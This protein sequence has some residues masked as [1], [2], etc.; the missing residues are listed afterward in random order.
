MIPD[1]YTENA[2]Q[3]IQALEKEGNINLVIIEIVE[4]YTKLRAFRPELMERVSFYL[5]NFSQLLSPEMIHA[6][7]SLPLEDLQNFGLSDK[8][9]AFHVTSP[10]PACG[11]IYFP[12]ISTRGQ[13]YEIRIIKENMKTLLPL[14]LELLDQ[15]GAPAYSV[16]Q[17][18]LSCNLFWDP[19][20][21][22]FQIL[23]TFGREDATVSGESMGLP[24]ALALY[25]IETKKDL[26]PN[27]S[28]TA[29][30]KRDGSVEPVAG[31]KEK[32]TAL[33]RERH[34]VNTVFVS[35]RQEINFTIR[36]LKIVKVDSLKD[37]INMA[38]TGPVDPSAFPAGID[39]GA[40][41]SRIKRQYKNHLIDTCLG[42]A[43]RLTGYLE[44][45]NCPISREKAAEALF[46][47]YW[48]RGSCHCHKGQVE[49]TKRNLDKAQT[50][51]NKYKGN[52]RPHTYLN[53][54]IN[55][56]VHLK[57]IFRYKEAEDLHKAISSEAKRITGVDWEKAKNLSSLSQLY[58]AQRRFQEAVDLQKKA[59]S[60]FSKDEMHRNYNYL[61]LIY[62]RN[63]DFSKAARAFRQTFTLL[64]QKDLDTREEDLSFY[65][66]YYSEYLYRNGIN[67][68]R[69]VKKSF[70]ELQEIAAHY[71]DITWYVPALIHKFSGLAFLHEGKE[72][73]GLKD[74]ERATQFFDS[75]FDAMHRLLGATVRAERALYLLETGQ[76]DE[77]AGDVR[78]IRDSL[79]AQKDIKQFFIKEIMKIRDYL[80]FKYLK[81][82]RIQGMKKILTIVKK[83]IPY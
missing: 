5:D 20:Q 26:P 60:I 23:D 21:F 33:S 36:G 29:A 32:L 81:E 68:K 9:D 80:R 16:L 76:I 24:L 19:G 66:L 38:F 77:A 44:T 75:R 64:E 61:G 79:S 52:I 28:A 4:H 17:D 7:K 1:H 72:T 67:Q 56:G 65:H 45:K 62:T 34:F 47:C 43:L 42:N 18:S 73:K 14:R 22:S 8:L 50:L 37:A 58:L 2:F 53:M 83:K 25:S 3:K 71:P 57:D 49:L 40:E 41:I 6:L 46:V 82:S 30:V 13:V 59:I 70:Q 12:V 48:R 10:A 74:L 27:L 35:K 55:H 51:Y 78:S 11:Q 15:V 63:A 54:K 69:G 39:V 31:L